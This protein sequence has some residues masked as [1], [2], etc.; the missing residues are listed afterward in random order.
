MGPTGSKNHCFDELSKIKFLG[1]DG[2]FRESTRLVVNP[3][4]M[5]GHFI[6]E[7]IIPEIPI[8]FRLISIFHYDG[9]MF[10][11][12]CPLCVQLVCESWSNVD[13]CEKLKPEL[14]HLKI[15]IYFC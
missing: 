2:S 7:L 15:N 9:K 5:D 12:V 6:M 13:R 8:N 10:F 14:L 1:A 3:G 11:P 4:H